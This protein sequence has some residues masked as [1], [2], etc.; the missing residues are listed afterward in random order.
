MK[1]VAIVGCGNYMDHCYGCPGDWKCL[2]AATLGEGLFAEESQVIA[3]VR[4]EC[5]GRT[6]VPNTGF[7][8]RLAQMAPDAIHLSSCIALV[9]PDCPYHTP[10]QFAEMLEEKTGV[11]VVLGT[12]EY[13]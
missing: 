9:K 13:M 11:D 3:F 6:V 5:P 8:F 2:K 1:R 4:C 10:E 12:H 7:A